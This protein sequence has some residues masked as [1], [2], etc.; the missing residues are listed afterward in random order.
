L[1]LI[2]VCVCTNYR[3][4]QRTRAIYTS[5]G[6]NVWAAV[7][8]FDGFCVF[9]SSK[10]ANSLYYH[11]S[12]FAELASLN[13]KFFAILVRRTSFDFFKSPG[14]IFSVFEANLHRNLKNG[15]IG[16]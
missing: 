6:T 11:P 4:T 12:G 8:L 10:R 2:L 9:K 7:R 1:T 13:A 15:F 3:N 16:L 14:N 5:Y